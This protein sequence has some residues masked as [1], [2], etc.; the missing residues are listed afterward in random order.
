MIPEP[1]SFFHNAIA[2]PELNLIFKESDFHL[3]QQ[4]FFM[5]LHA[6]W[7]AHLNHQSDDLSPDHLSSFGCIIPHPACS[8]T[9]LWD[10]GPWTTHAGRGVVVYTVT[11]ERV[12]GAGRAAATGTDEE[13]LRWVDRLEDD[14]GRWV[15]R[16]RDRIT[17]WRGKK[18]GIILGITL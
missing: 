3:P 17:W 18:K 8:L 2:W 14:Q 4:S 15:I 5:C 7:A 12:T 11:T 9:G 6:H 1:C 16:V 13:R 10:A